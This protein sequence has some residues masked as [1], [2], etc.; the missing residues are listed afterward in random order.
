MYCA[1]LAAPG[2]PER[3][4]ARSGPDS[5]VTCPRSR[6]IRIAPTD[7]NAIMRAAVSN[8]NLHV[9]IIASIRDGMSESKENADRDFSNAQCLV[10]NAEDTI[11]PGIDANPDRPSR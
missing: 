6:S 1:A 3:L 9:L 10:L 5:K 11:P 4:P 7:T 8:L 2:C